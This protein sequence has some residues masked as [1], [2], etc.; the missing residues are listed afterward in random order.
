MFLKSAPYHTLLFFTV[1]TMIAIVLMFKNW[2]SMLLTGKTINVI[3][4]DGR[5]YYSYLT[6]FFITHDLHKLNAK[7]MF[8][9][10]TPTGNINM[11]PSGVAT[12]QLPFFGLG[13][14]WAKLQNA[15]ING[16]STPFQ[17]AIN[18]SGLFYMIL[19]LWFTYKTLLLNG[20]KKIVV[21]S[22]V[23]CLAFGTTL[24]NYGI[25]EPSMSHVYSFALISV[26]IFLNQQLTTRYSKKTMY[27]I[28]LVFG[29]ILL[30]RPIDGLIILVLPFL[31]HSF[32]DFKCRLIEICKDFKTL[33][34]SA[35][36][37]ILVFSIQ[38]LIWYIQ[39]GEFVKNS[40]TDNGFYFNKPH[41][42]HML[43]GFNSGIIPY[44][45]LFILIPIGILI[46]FFKNKFNALVISL[47]IG[48]S[49]YLYSC[50][51]AWTYFDGIGTRVF[52]DY[53]IIAAIL[54]AYLFSVV[55]TTFYKA[56]LVLFSVCSI[57]FNFII[58]YQYKEQIIQSSGMNFEKY[59]YVFLKTDKSYV[60]CL[61]GSYD[62][63]PYSKQVKESYNKHCYEFT[64]SYDYA[65]IVTT[66]TNRFLNY[67]GNDFG[68]A[69]YKIN[70]DKPTK[71][72]FLEIDYEKLEYSVK[73]ANHVVMAIAHNDR[74]NKS[75]NFQTFKLN[76]V[77]VTS[78]KANWS[79]HNYSFSMIS[80]FEKNDKLTVFIW[81]PKGEC[82]GIDNLAIRMYDFGIS[83]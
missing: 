50:Y 46:L 51:W 11:H 27:L 9:V 39:T 12:L 26:F 80:N 24:L 5:D 33:M 22:T 70:I 42:L 44:T 37:T 81:N 59:S 25:N 68:L 56:S 34:L 15:N 4:G 8:V 53:Y 20:F 3:N 18:I 35:L 47:F 1:T 7:N 38:M 40:Y 23:F 72:I 74:K 76:D 69:S 19:G 54:L 60:N 58:C 29:F 2:Q 28:G 6:S 31:Y 67:N 13:Y 43:F 73:H 55:H 52:V 16:I 83:N 82:F 41:I 45:P 79:K 57:A 65:H 75:K 10:Q 32:F 63:K 71:K 49:L 48:F 77:P 36:I 78:D 66:R 14:V 17:K 62:M 30:V 64:K 21:Y 61:G